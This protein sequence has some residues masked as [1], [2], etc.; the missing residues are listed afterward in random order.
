MDD[1]IQVLE[2]LRGAAP[3]RRI[4]PRQAGAGRGD[5]ADRAA[6]RAGQPGVAQLRG[7]LRGEPGAASRRRRASPPRCATSSGC[8]TLVVREREARAHGRPARSA[9]SGRRV[10][11]DHAVRRRRHARHRPHP[12]RHR[13]PAPGRRAAC[14]TR[15]SAPSGPSATRRW[16]TCRPRRRCGSTGSTRRTICCDSYGFGAGRGGLRARGQSAA[17][18]RSQERLGARAS[19]AVSGRGHHGLVRGAGAGAGHRTGRGR[20]RIVEQR[21]SPVSAGW[22]I[23]DGWVWSPLGPGD[24]SPCGPAAPDSPMD[25]AA[26]LLGP[27]RRGRH[28]PR[29]LQVSPGTFR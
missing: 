9:A 19:R 10:G 17:R 14:I 21:R 29:R 5:G 12:A 7:A 2:L 6:H 4:H 20:A 1:L 18:A 8:A 26:R 16:R 28:P 23:S 27:R 15:T 3:L 11:D 25:R 24:F 13:Q 22:P